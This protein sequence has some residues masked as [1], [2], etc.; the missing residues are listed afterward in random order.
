MRAY[1]SWA[2]ARWGWRS[3][4]VRATRCAA[5][6][7]PFW[8]NSSPRRRNTKLLGSWASWEDRL[9]MSSGMEGRPRAGQRLRRALGA[10]HDLQLGQFRL[11]ARRQPLPLIPLLHGFG[12]ATDP[13]QPVAERAMGGDEQRV[14]PQGAAQLLDRVRSPSGAQ[15]D[16]P[17]QQVDGG[18]VGMHRRRPFRDAAGFFPVAAGPGV[19]GPRPPLRQIG[20]QG[21]ALALR[22]APIRQ[23]DEP[24]ALQ[25]QQ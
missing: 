8:R 25:S 13:D 4:P 24:G 21:G 2:S 23:D 22:G 12:E 6:N 19:L 11:R 9:L 14:E 5:S 1:R 3:S 15:G 17:E 18:V 10:V 16:P 20:R 7:W